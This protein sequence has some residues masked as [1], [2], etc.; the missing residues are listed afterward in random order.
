MKEVDTVTIPSTG[1]AKSKY[2]SETDAPI[3]LIEAPVIRGRN[4]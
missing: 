3:P 4:L 1:E 2:S